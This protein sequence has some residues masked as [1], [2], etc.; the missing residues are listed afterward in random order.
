MRIK[1][2]V[3]EEN[4]YKKIKP[5]GIYKYQMVQKKG[6]CIFLSN[7]KCTIYEWRPLICRFYPFTMIE[8][9]SYVF[10]VDADCPGVNLGKCITKKDLAKLIE[11]AI[12]V[13]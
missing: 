1:K 5:N 8:N 4:F 11:E 10:Q 12:R 9:E 3:V 7:N 2:D 6:A 13:S